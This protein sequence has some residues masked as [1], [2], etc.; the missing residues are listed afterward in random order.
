M[1]VVLGSSKNRWVLWGLKK[2]SEIDLSKNKLLQSMNK[3]T[4]KCDKKL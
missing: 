2:S 3:V 1:Q 4:T